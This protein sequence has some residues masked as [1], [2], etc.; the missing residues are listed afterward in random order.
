MDKI[1]D[2]II[3]VMEI[4]KIKNVFVVSLRCPASEFA[5][6]PSRFNKISFLSFINRISNSFNSNFN[7]KSLS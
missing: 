3:R 4:S 7:L 6:N 1:C 2:M 5:F